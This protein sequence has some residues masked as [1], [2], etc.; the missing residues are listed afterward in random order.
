MKSF[1][2]VRNTKTIGFASKV[3]RHVEFGSAAGCEYFWQS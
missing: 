1:A 2:V 3:I